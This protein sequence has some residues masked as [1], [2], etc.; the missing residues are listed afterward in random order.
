M[1]K[2][3]NTLNLFAK[4]LVLQGVVVCAT[5][6][7]PFEDVAGSYDSY[8]VTQ[9]QVLELEKELSTLQ[10]DIYKRVGPFS[11]LEDKFFKFKV[12]KTKRLWLIDV[13]GKE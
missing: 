7:L 3:Y 2:K 12:F 11:R 4:L 9:I 10:W 8:P 13:V 6:L 5:K 1:L